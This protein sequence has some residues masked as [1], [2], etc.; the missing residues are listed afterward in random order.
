MV[1]D[2]VKGYFIRVCTFEK[3]KSIF[4]ERTTNIDLEIIT[5]DHSIYTMDHPENIAC[6]HMENSIS[7]KRVNVHR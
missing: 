1:S 2:L 6:S 3:A 5:C 7:L 4:S